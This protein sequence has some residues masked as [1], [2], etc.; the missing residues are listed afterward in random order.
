M[1]GGE[2]QVAEERGGGR[3][4]VGAGD[5]HPQPAPLP[6]QLPQEGLPRDDRN[7]P[8]S[9]GDELGQVRLEAERGA[10]RNPIDP[11]QV[12]WIVAS[13]HCDAQSG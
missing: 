4:A 6:H 1:P 8:F 11:F 3:L 10:D 2:E 5:G 7:P 13:N 9:R 12:G